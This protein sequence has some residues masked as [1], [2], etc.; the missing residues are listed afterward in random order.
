MRL[1][2]PLYPRALSG[3][4]TISSL[5]LALLS[6][7]ALAQV[8]IISP[9]PNS[10]DI[11][12]VRITA[13][14]RESESFHLEIWDNGFKLGNVFASNVD[15]VYVLPN[16]PHTLAVNA[17]SSTGT[18]LDGSSVRYGVAENC[19]TS[20]SVQCDLD[21]QGID[22][23]QNDCNPPQE[24]IWVANPCG[25]GIQGPNGSSP[26]S[27]NIQ[28]T[29]EF[30]TIP[31][32]GNITLNGRA[33]H[34]SETQ[35]GGGLS[36][37]IF[38]TESPNPTSPSSVDSHWTLDEYVYIPNPAAH[39]AFELDAQYVIDGVWTKFYTECAFNMDGNGG[40]Y[41]GVFDNHEGGWIFLNGQ[42]Q[43]DQQLPAVPCN[44]SQFAQPWSG[45]TNPSF[46][47]WHH[48]VW[49]FL[50][51]NN[52]EITYQGVTFDAQTWQ[53]NF[54][55]HSGTGGLVSNNGDFGALVQLDG[56]TN[57]DGLYDTVDAYVNEINITHVK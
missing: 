4:R 38:K 11:S 44:R 46:T 25:S 54:T 21:Q 40:G 8:R 48:V 53:L 20:G 24:A 13:S 17:V 33:L 6:I 9:A 39:Q 50:R 37:V 2:R 42:G 56:S 10:T 5:V 14:A 47:G 12:A 18:L 35:G 7:P 32:Q 27:T 19:T 51:K 49:S 34:L 26:I 16:G 41:W 23:T 3:Q 43:G 55:P 57:P 36:N 45:S 22:N 52:G 30:G 31:D 1:V 29:T 15:G 28:D